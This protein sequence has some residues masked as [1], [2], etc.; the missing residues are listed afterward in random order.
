MKQDGGR[1][2]NEPAGEERRRR[3]GDQ[4]AP[5]RNGIRRRARSVIAPSSG[6]STKMMPVRE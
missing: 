3:D 4:R 5:D 6:D 1:M 2:T